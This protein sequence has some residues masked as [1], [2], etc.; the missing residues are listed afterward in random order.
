MQL[1]ITGDHVIDSPLHLAISQD[2]AVEN[3]VVAQGTHSVTPDTV[4]EIIPASLTSDVLV[5]LF[6]NTDNVKFEWGDGSSSMSSTAD[7]G[8]GQI[9][10]GWPA[11]IP[12]KGGEGMDIVDAGFFASADASTDKIT[13]EGHGLSDGDTVHFREVTAGSG[14]SNDTDYTVEAAT[15]DDFE[16]DAGMGTI[17]IILDNDYPDLRLFKYSTSKAQ[18]IEYAYFTLG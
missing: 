14:F 13:S 4:S 8:R 11:I 3:P 12:I 2:I 5:Y 1:N 15:V 17:T 6:N 18:S 16:I 9:Y 10:P 7:S